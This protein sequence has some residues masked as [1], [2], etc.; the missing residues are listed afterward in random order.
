MLVA[1]DDD[2][3]LDGLEAFEEEDRQA[4]EALSGH[5][6]A[7]HASPPALVDYHY[8]PVKVEHGSCENRPRPAQKFWPAARNPNTDPMVLAGQ[9]WDHH[10]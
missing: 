4:R 2:H 10:P 9:A 1:D 8:R 3:G 7:L 6:P 5:C